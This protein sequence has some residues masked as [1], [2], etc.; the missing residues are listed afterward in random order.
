MPHKDKEAQKAANRRSYARNK[1][2]VG[3]KVKAYKTKLRQAWK[4]YKATLVCAVCG[5]NDP[6]ALDFHHAV[7][8]PS[9]KKLHILLRNG[10]YDSAYEETKKCIVLCA[11]CHRKHHQKERDEKRGAEAPPD[12][13]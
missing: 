6:A 3:D 11:N 9:N 4:A 2:S 10:A 7:R 13:A 1:K 12:T 5:E 8:D